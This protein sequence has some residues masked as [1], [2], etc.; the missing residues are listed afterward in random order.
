MNIEQ[1]ID[2]LEQELNELKEQAE[3]CKPKYWK[4]KNGEKAW[5]V[6]AA[7]EVDYDTRWLGEFDKKMIKSGLVFKT[8]EEAKKELELILATQRLKEAIWEANGGEFI[9]FTSE[10]INYTITTDSKTV[11][12]NW[13]EYVKTAQ[14]WMYI[15]DI[16]TAE[17]VLEENRKDFEIYYGLN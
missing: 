17:K 11:K 7:S 15:K 8:K 16:E 9:G 5:Y 4:P 10:V 2:K 6:Y 12:V 14:D 3:N 13:F 1:K